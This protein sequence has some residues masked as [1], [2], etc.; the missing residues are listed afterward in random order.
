MA[1]FSEKERVQI[2]GFS[3]YR[4]VSTTVTGVTKG[5]DETAYSVD[6]D[7]GG[8]AIVGEDDLV[9]PG[10]KWGGTYSFGGYS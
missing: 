8:I 5:Q 10:E 1:R 4:G 6:L 2:A 9:R 3:L 7:V